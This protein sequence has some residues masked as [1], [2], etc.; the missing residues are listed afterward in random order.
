VLRAIEERD[1]ETLRAW[2]NHPALRKY[3]REYRELTFIDQAKWFESLSGDANTMMFAIDTGQLV[4]CCGLINI[5]WLNRSAEVSI[6]IGGLAGD[7][8]YI[9]DNAKPALAE[10]ERRAFDEYGLHRL[11]AEVYDLDIKKQGLLEELGYKKEGELRG[12]H[13]YQGGFCNS[14]IYA[15]VI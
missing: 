14:Y 2:R 9:N 13:F 10:L 6:Y 1:L 7:P 5:D 15:K 12:S 4:G 8:A 11:W 3:F